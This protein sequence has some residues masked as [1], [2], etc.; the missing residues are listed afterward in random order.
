[1]ADQF[2]S[3]TKKELSTLSVRDLFYKYV[4]YLP[5]FLLSV[6]LTL[7]GAYAYLRY[8]TPI[9]SVSGTIYIKS[10]DQ[11]GRSDKF[12]EMFVNDKAA[13]IASEIEVLKSRPL[14]ERVVQS[15]GL[16]FNYYAKGKIKKVDVYKGCGFTIK[17]LQ[18]QDSAQ[19]FSLKVKFFDQQHFTVDDADLNIG[20]NQAFKNQ[21]GVFMLEPSRGS[22]SR[23]YEV[24]WVPTEAMAAQLA[25]VLV[26]APKTAGT[27]ILTISMQTPNAQ[28]GADVINQ[29]M[30]EYRQ[31]NIDEKKSSSDSI[32][33]FIDGRLNEYGHALDSTQKDL[34]EFQQRNDL[35]D[36]ETQYG[37]YFS[38]IQ[39]ADESIELE[40]NRLATVNLV[41][42]YL[43]D[44][45]NEFNKVPSTISIEDLTLREIVTGYNNAQLERQQLIDANVPVDN[46]RVKEAD[47]QLEKLRS[48]ALENLKNLKKAYGENVDALR[49]RS[50]SAQIQLRGMPYK[51]MDYAERKRRVEG[52]QNLYKILQEQ[53][54]ATSISR[55]S[56][57]ANSKIV[58]RAMPS[59]TPVKPNGL[60]IKALA[61]MLGLMI[62]AGVIFIAE[63]LNDKVS[64][65]FDVERLTSVPIVG[66]V[67]HSFSDNVLI[68]NKTT[69]SMVAE[70]FRIIRS[71]LQYVL[72]TGVGEKFVVLVT[73]SFSGEG[74]SFVSTN[75]GA[76][77]SLPGKK[78]VILE[79][80]I[81]K[82]KVLSGLNMAKGRGITNFL[83]G[84]AEI[85]ALI[86]PV[87]G[88]D[89]L[90]VIGCGP[91]P[92][93][94]SELL[95]DA[96]VDEFFAELKNR[97][98]VIIIDTAPVGMVSD[99]MTLGKFADCSL[100]LVRQGHTFKKQVALIDEFYRDGKLPKVS[101]VIND[102]KLKAGYGYY[103]YGR[104]GYGYGYG[105]GSYYE[106]EH[107][108]RTFADRVV[109]FFDVRNWFKK[110]K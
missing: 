75:M 65:R 104:Y 15:L 100:Y 51:V 105:Y 96:K 19:G 85:D 109:G 39:A 55:A 56:T 107:A 93:N 32:L 48:M 31:Y 76:V 53:K 103:G 50:G 33:A 49:Q 94:P 40:K 1:M 30:T 8:A 18:L 72:G 71:N 79:F 38:S 24:D 35:I 37:N 2:T 97:F 108:P 23:E 90:F 9:Y 45:R 67:G 26:V 13:N 87:D 81:R 63:I 6:A 102:V 41:N 73:S 101:I 91:V 95:L 60:A 46:P 4:R 5:V 92:P 98:D 47:D 43:G 17:A 36:V 14:M 28:K 10:D 68:V 34:L 99:A 77:L 54:E 66:E 27:G 70:Q 7:F 84:K 83:V 57:I 88:Y 64:S 42:D 69:R 82:P 11:G 62:P 61:I 25:G 3:T 59:E 58:D 89:D 21:Y 16:Q 86:R 12:E 106:E 29:L 80:D 22:L 78:T 20:F 44:R 52:L 74:K 110:K